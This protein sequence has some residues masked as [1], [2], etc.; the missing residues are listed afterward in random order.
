MLDFKRYRVLTFDCYGTLIDWESGIL[1]ALAPVRARSDRRVS[2]D[3]LLECYALAESKIQRGEY[4]CYREILRAVLLEVTAYL[5]VPLGRSEEELLADSVGDWKPFPDTVGALKTLGNHYRLAVISNIDDDLFARSALRLEAQFDWVVTAEQVRSYK[6]SQ[7]NFLRALERMN[8]PRN[9]VLH[10]AQSRYH[11]IEPAS[12]LGLDCVWVNRRR[13]K[14]GFGATRQS[15]AVP[16]L[17]V[18]NLRELA[19]LVM[20]AFAV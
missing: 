5:G 11:D 18:A 8:V 12:K 14:T 15:D 16:S 20:R 6:P 2:G 13:G 19:G 7:N 9:H 17:E 10:V 4:R 3:E 1:T